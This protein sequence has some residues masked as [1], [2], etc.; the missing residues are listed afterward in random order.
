VHQAALAA[1]DGDD[2]AR[3]GLVSDVGTCGFDSKAL[4]G[5]QT[6]CGAINT[7]EAEVIKLIW[8]GPRRRDGSRLWNGIDPAVLIHAPESPRIWANPFNDGKA[9]HPDAFSLAG[10]AAQF[11]QFIE[12]YG[13]VMDTS[14]P[15]L[16]AFATQGKTI[17]W[18]GVADDIVPAAGTVHYVDSIRRTLGV[19][20]TDKFLRF[21]LAPGVGHCGGGDG[22]QPTELLEPLMQ[23]VEHGRAPA[24]VTSVK[25]D[26]AGRVTRTRPLCPYPQRVRYRGRGSLDDAASFQCRSPQ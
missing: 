16:S 22:P 23:W 12:R 24:I 10:F 21:Y 8:D 4:V 1:C 18:H 11:D 5:L 3:D 25:T 6:E 15:D 9:P 13:A 7:Q 14:N 17:L 19:R 26:E 2:G 20:E